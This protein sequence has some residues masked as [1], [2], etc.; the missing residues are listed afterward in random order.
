MCVDTEP[1]SQ[2][3][4]SL[5]DRV[6]PDRL[7]AVGRQARRRSPSGR[8]EPRQRGPPRTRA[9]C[10]ASISTVSLSSVRPAGS[11]GSW[12]P[13]PR[14]RP[15]IW[16]MLG[17][18]RLPR[19]RRGRVPDQRSPQSSPRRAPSNHRQPDEGPPV[20]SFH[21]AVTIFA[22]SAAVGGEG[23]RV[24]VGGGSTMVERIDRDPSPPSGPVSEPL[25]IAWTTRMLPSASGWHRRAARHTAGSRGMS[26]GR[27]RSTR[28]CAWRCA[29]RR[30]A[31]LLCGARCSRRPRQ[32]SLQRREAARRGSRCLRV[33]PGDRYSPMVGRMCFSILPT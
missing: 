13:S 1:R 7:R 25:R 21:A 20:G 19:R 5:G 24:G 27:A 28:T 3:A 23:F 32:C 22:A 9:W 17:R 10:S 18:T 8:T 15:A 11:D 4:V 31:R 30:R 12:C 14:S 29:H 33:E 16:P 26:S 6:G 2:P